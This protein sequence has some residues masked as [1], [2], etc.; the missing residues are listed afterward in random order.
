MQ[1]IKKQLTLQL[2]RNQLFY[3]QNRYIAS[4]HRQFHNSSLNQSDEIRKIVTSPIFYV[5]ATPHIGH[6]YTAILCDAITR[7]HKLNGEQVLFST[8][9]DEH[10]QKVQKKAIEAG[11]DPK[12]FCDKNSDQFKSLFTLA[13]IDYDRFIRTTDTDHKVAVWDFWNRLKDRGYIVEGVHEGYYSVNDESFISEKDLKA[14][15]SGGFTTETGEKLEFISEKNYIFDIDSRLKKVIESWIKDAIIKP[16]HIRNKLLDELH[17]RKSDISVSRP[18]SRI[19]WGLKVPNDGSQTIYVWLDALVN[20]LTVLGYPQNMRQNGKEI[21]EMIH[22]VGK[23]IAKFHC[24]YWPAFLAADDLPLPKKIINHGHWLKNNMKMSKSIGNVIDPYEILKSYGSNSVRSYF[25][26]QGPQSKDRN[27]EMNDLI[28]HHNQIICDQY[29]NLLQRISGKKILKNRT[30]LQ[31]LNDEQIQYIGVSFESSINELS[32]QVIKHFEEY[33]FVSAFTII[34][35]ILYLG[36]HLLAENQFWNIKENEQIEALLFTTFEI[37]RVSS[38]LLQP[39][40]PQLA[41][42]MLDVQNIQDRALINAKVNLK[43]EINL[44]MLAKEKVYLAKV[45]PQQTQP[46]QKNRK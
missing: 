7:Y 10:G 34:E 14:D 4:Q 42:G 24:I 26:S 44:N 6:L 3:Q 31:P 15:Q 22:V 2:K 5:N 9:T 25:L 27:F 43:R 23:D 32:D 21:G 8:G 19:S 17:T 11:I 37:L 40:I 30:Q 20:Y 18:T 28:D 35:Q 41:S 33:D 46:Q 12:K 1:A 45:E 13:Q 38:I 16:D 36:N 29:L 39:Y